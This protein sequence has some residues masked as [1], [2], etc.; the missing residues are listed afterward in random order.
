MS[1]T[2]SEFMI[3]VVLPTYNEKDN[4]VKLIQE[5]ESLLTKEKMGFEVAVV[6]D[7]SPDGTADVVRKLNQKYHNIKVFVREKKLGIGSAH[8]FGY[9]KV[10]GDIVI[11]MDTDLS[12]DP[13][14]MLAMIKKINEGYDMVVG[15]RH[16]KG[17]YYE[18][19]TPETRKKFVASR[20]GNIITT[21]VSRVPIHDFTNG[22]RAIRRDII[23]N[24]KTSSTGNS[25]LM[26]FIVK[27]YKRGYRITEVP[28]TFMD[29]KF[30]KSKLKL[31]E[32]SI[33][34]FKDLFKYSFE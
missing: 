13:R 32:E 8:M 14:Q 22:Y 4:I 24:V 33:K 20:L 25:F 3:S 12:H 1:R 2:E 7:N 6:D 31:G 21:L 28:V 29:R 27:A 17:A 10:K 19:K 11:A 5:I 30:G 18:K 34:Y 15:S 26:E 16:M 9:K 23:E